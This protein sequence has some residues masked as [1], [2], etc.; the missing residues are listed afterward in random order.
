MYGWREQN[1][2]VVLSTESQLIYVVL[3]TTCHVLNY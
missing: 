2:T 1:K 3:L